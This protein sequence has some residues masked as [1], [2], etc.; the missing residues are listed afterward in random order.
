MAKQGR[1]KRA[2]KPFVNVTYWVNYDE[3]KSTWSKLL[4]SVTSLLFPTLEPKRKETFEQAVQ[5]MNISERGL[6][7]R[8]KQCLSFAVLFFI[9]G[10]ILLVYTASLLLNKEF[11]AS[12]L[13]IG[14]TSL[15]FTYAFRYHFWYFQI[16]NRRLGCSLAEWWSSKL[17]G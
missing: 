17:K 1:I 7:T 10:V 2:V 11:A 4:A 13:G 16:K 5:R 9:A 12:F 15:V 14:V 3:H 8:Q 6:A